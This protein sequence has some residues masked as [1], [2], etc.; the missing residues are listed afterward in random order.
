MHGLSPCFVGF[1]THSFPRNAP[2]P[3]SLEVDTT[4]LRCYR[5]TLLTSAGTEHG[6]T[7]QRSGTQLLRPLGGC[8]ESVRTES[9][10]WLPWKPIIGPYPVLTQFK[11][12]LTSC[13][14]G[15]H[16]NYFHYSLYRSLGLAEDFDESGLSLILFS[17]LFFFLRR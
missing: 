8:S 6:K 16:F 2:K 14:S 10:S 17:I 15:I 1:T 9:S 7:W 12:F 4:R 3:C 13:F 5:V 11:N